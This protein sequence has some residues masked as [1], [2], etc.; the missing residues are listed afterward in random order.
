MTSLLKTL[1]NTYNLEW[2]LKSSGANTIY[3]LFF[4]VCE[5]LGMYYPIQYTLVICGYLY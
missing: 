2:L 4:F 5:Y 3:L 1:W